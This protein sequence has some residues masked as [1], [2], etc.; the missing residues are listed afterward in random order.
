MEQ[1]QKQN[2]WR[3]AVQD[4]PETQ[5][6]ISRKVMTLLVGITYEKNEQT[7]YFPESELA[8]GEFN[9]ID[10]MGVIYSYWTVDKYNKWTMTEE[11]TP[12]VTHWKEIEDAIQT[13]LPNISI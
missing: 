4:P 8:K 1:S 11:V 13:S 2:K 3:N 6:G 10:I 12:V 5:L 9:E 7:I